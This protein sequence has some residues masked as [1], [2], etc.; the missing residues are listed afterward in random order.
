MNNTKTIQSVAQ[1]ILNNL[2]YKTRPD[3][4]WYCY[5]KNTIEWQQDIIYGAHLDRV[6]SDDIYDRIHSILC[7]ITEADEDADIDDMYDIVREMSFEDVDCYTVDL[8]GWLASHN[9]NV[10]YLT[11]ALDRYDVEKDGFNLLRYAQL[12]YI[13]EIAE[14]LLSAIDNYIDELSD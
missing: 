7:V 1:E 14:A 3:G 6:P 13:Q 9:G 10:Y 2:E 11:Q 8:T 12:L 4:S 5:Q